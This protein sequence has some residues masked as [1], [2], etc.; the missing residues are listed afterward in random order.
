MIFLGGG[1][2]SVGCMCMSVCLSVCE[3]CESDRQR[4][5]KNLLGLEQIR[6]VHISFLSFLSSKSFHFGPPKAVS[7]LL[8][9][10]LSLPGIL[11]P[12]PPSFLWSS[13]VLIK[14]DSSESYFSPVHSLNRANISECRPL[15][16]AR[17]RCGVTCAWH[18]AGGVHVRPPDRADGRMQH[19]SGRNPDGLLGPSNFQR[20]FLPLN[21]SNENSLSPVFCTFPKSH[22]YFLCSSSCPHMLSANP[23]HQHQGFCSGSLGQTLQER[24]SFRVQT[25]ICPTK[26]RDVVV[27]QVKGFLHFWCL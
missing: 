12:F 22:L 26:I 1:N 5:V 21:G 19:E 3:V 2:I 7:S 13:G 23:R 24:R 18:R 15:P 17:H 10:D 25:V 9:S 6:K 14:S 16:A 27:L 20:A 8:S 11:C 4:L